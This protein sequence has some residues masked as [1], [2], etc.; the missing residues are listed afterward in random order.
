MEALGRDVSWPAVVDI[1]DHRIALSVR[2]TRSNNDVSMLLVNSSALE[3]RDSRKW[4]RD[5]WNDV[6]WPLTEFLNA[7]R[8]P[9][10]P[11]V[12]IRMEFTG[13]KAHQG[14]EGCTIF[15]LSAAKK[16]ASDPEIG[17]VHARML[18]ELEDGGRSVTVRWADPHSV[19]PP[20]F[21][22]HATSRKVITDYLAARTELREA[23]AS[24]SH[25]VEEPLTD[26]NGPVNK[27]GQGLLERFDS[28]VV[29]RWDERNAQYR[30]F[31]N[32]YESKRIELIATA[33]A[34]LTPPRPF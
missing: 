29:Q 32:S 21:Y 4:V 3:D 26:P 11:P 5:T 34:H 7:R 2:C 9:S 20:S 22:K 30:R 28:H 25:S 8:K 12:R 31:S 18:A 10:Q 27:R 19:L 6:L 17:R 33:L 14:L 16:L 24:S 15:A 1:D 13:S 23:G